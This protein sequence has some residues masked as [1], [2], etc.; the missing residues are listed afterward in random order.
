[1][2]SYPPLVRYI[3]KLLESPNL[4]CHR[5]SNPSV[6][7]KGKT[8]GFAEILLLP[9]RKPIERVFLGTS[10]LLE[11][12]FATEVPEIPPWLPGPRGLPPPRPLTGRCGTKDRWREGKTAGCDTGSGMG[13]RGQKWGACA[14]VTK[15]GCV[16]TNKIII[17]SSISSLSTKIF[18]FRII[19]RLWPYVQ[20][21]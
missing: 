13:S 16:I 2:C 10:S 5:N 15:I 9:I 12:Q 6:Y 20:I 18:L 17:I 1:M 4:I 21:W 8:R 11:S 14:M 19:S 7:C 3:W